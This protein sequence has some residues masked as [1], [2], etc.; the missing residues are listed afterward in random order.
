MAKRF[1]SL[2]KLYDSIRESSHDFRITTAPFK[3]FDPEQLERTLEL[4]EKGR[5][6]G[7]ANL[8]P[9]TSKEPDDVEKAI[10][11]RIDSERDDAY[12][13][14]EDRLNDY[15]TRIRNF[16]FDGHFSHVRMTNNSSV[17]DF[18]A[19]VAT[20]RDEL[21]TLRQR[22]RG[23]D[24]ELADFRERNGLEKRV[25]QTK[26]AGFT[27]LKWLVIIV[28]LIVETALNG[29]FLAEG[30][31]QGLVGGYTVAFAFAFANVALT[32]LNAF[33]VIPRIVHRS[34]FQKL[35]GFLG[36]VFW[37]FFAV[38]VNFVLAHFRE[39]SALAPDNMG[40][41]VVD[42]MRTSTF[43][44]TSI[45][46]WILFVSG[47]IFSL[48]ALVDTLLMKD[49][50][51]GY[52]GTYQRYLDK[53]DDY[54][55]TKIELIDALK[56][57]RDEHNAKVEEIIRALSN[58]R[59]DSAS[60]IDARARMIKLF[61]EHQAHLE[62]VAKRLLGTYREANRKA[63]SE[64]EPTRFSAPF[65]LE[66]RKADVDKSSDWSDKE[67][68]ERINA[69]QAELVEQMARISKEFDDAVNSYHQL[70]NL[71]PE[72]INGATRQS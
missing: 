37:I 57:T 7:S 44:F 49:I 36:V 18:R 13:V 26:S 30:S 1:E 51:P 5:A 11:E 53:Q 17:D 14:L 40:A 43:D 65:K 20:G 66:R 23:A 38:L 67:L 3:Q 33:F 15:A 45:N 24:V 41:A 21:H 61:S 63:R 28:L 34:I 52:A 71:F 72:T 19:S 29:V 47:L 22:L 48:I 42:H 58:R 60:A 35:I 10:I 59:K 50:Y 27:I 62:S 39:V 70:D 31:D 25:A 46:S 54:I 69:A 32:V 6:N 2:N 4:E 8:P 12:Q 64:P 16:D 55:D 56:K 9:P 68:A